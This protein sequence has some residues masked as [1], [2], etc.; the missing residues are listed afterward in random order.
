MRKL[1]PARLRQF[2]ALIN[3]YR[4]PLPFAAHLSEFFRRHKEMGSKD[5]KDLRHLA[6][7]WLRAGRLFT[8]LSLEEQLLMS[9]TFTQLAAEEKFDEIKK[10][11]SENNIPTELLFPFNELLNAE[12]KNQ[13]FYFSHMLQPYVWLRIQKGKEQAVLEDLRQQNLGFLINDIDTIALPPESRL[14]GLPEWKA[15]HIRIQ[16]YSSQKTAA[17]FR[18]SG[19]ENWWDACAGGGGKSL[20]L[21]D[22]APDVRLWASDKRQQALGNLQERMRHGKYQQPRVNVID[23]EKPVTVK[24]PQFDGII[25]DAPCSGSG[26]WARN[27][28]SLKYYNPEDTSKYAERQYTI[29]RNTIPFLKAGKPLI[30]ITCSVFSQENEDLIASLIKGFPLEIEEQY[31]IKGYDKRAENMFICRLIKKEE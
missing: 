2:E 30:Y 31:Y 6:Y 20:L 26:T 11:F 28:E 8:E 23:L 12:F 29:V 17:I 3:G 18:A 1:F 27:P 14:E 7:S 4:Y 19:G 24:L 22:Q 13:E 9:D 5:R 25:L 10:I 21:L 15:G 16:D